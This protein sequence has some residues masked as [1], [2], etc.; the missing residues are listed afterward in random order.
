MSVEI[1][2]KI[3]K[4][5]R[6]LTA[7][8]TQTTMDTDIIVPD[9]KPDVKNVLQVE[10]LP[11]I[12]EKHIQKDYITLTGNVDYNILYLSDEKESPSALKAINTRVP[13]THQ[14]EAFGAE[15][16][17]FA[18]IKADVINVEF[19]AVNSRKI[20]VKSV[21]DFESNIIMSDEFQAVS[22][23]SAQ[24]DLP[25]KSRN[26]SSF[27]MVDFAENE[28]EAG[29]AFSIPSGSDMI[30]EILKVDVKVC[31]RE[32][33]SINGKLV[34]KGIVDVRALY[35][36]TS[37]QYRN[38]EGEIPFTE[39]LSV[40]DVDSSHMCEVEYTLTD[41]RYSAAADSDGD[42]ALMDVTVCVNA[43]TCVYAQSEESLTVDLYS[44]DFD[45]AVA[46][47]SISV[48]R[49]ICASND[50]SIIKD[51]VQLPAGAPSIS[52]IYNVIA[53]PYVESA[54][55]SGGKAHIS[56][57]TDTYLMYTSSSPDAP[58]SSFKK[59]IPF[60]YSVPVDCGDD[61]RISVICDADNISCSAASVNTAEVRF[62]L[63][64]DTKVVAE[65]DVLYIKDV[66][67]DESTAAERGTMP[68]IV[69]YFAAGGESMW[70]I[71]KRY[72]TTAEAISA[73]NGC[74]FPDVLTE[75]KQI[76]I[77]RR[78]IEN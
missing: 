59:E 29:D 45:V 20:N 37:G 39:V 13:F 17:T 58:V 71:A 48:N 11:H 33:K 19:S 14:L 15:A 75:P 31:G 8:G 68:G 7:G 32:V 10:V 65:E 54:E 57:V 62:N 35:S 16:A 40:A 43:A 30:D 1:E 53:K 64:F 60:A 23:V 36:V 9:I 67:A 47:D 41:L 38:M 27:A 2:R 12:R 78:K 56:G 69:I 22:A 25:C 6:T 55:I 28:F 76:M 26:V 63:N 61:A 46:R 74:E 77:P 3:I 34:A 44:P 49:L 72:H 66:E 52:G 42:M 24:G 73:A 4:T 5:H 51:T 18:G 70:D 50:Q 21:V